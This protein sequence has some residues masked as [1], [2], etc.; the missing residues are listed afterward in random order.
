MRSGFGLAVTLALGV[1]LGACAAPENKLVAAPDGATLT[2]VAEDYDLFP[3][4]DFNGEA[5]RLQRLQQQI[6]GQGLCPAGYTLTSR[7]TAEEPRTYKGN[8]YRV[9]YGLRCGT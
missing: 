9:T 5:W 4:R 7:E 3:M 1:G 2:F 8:L 6:K